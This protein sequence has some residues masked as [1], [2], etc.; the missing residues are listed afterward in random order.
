M[1]RQIKFK[2]WHTKANKMFS[3]EELGQ[4]ELT[5]NPDGRGFVNVSGTSQRLSQ[6][7]PDMIPLQYTGYRD[8]NGKEIYEGHIIKYRGYEVLNGKQTRPERTLVVEFTTEKLYQLH[9]IISMEDVEII[10]TIYEN[11][12]LN[13]NKNVSN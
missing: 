11:P 7:Y 3:A 4:D 12:E 13:Q 8:K 10:G 2:A 9:C 6:Y 1:T 5:L